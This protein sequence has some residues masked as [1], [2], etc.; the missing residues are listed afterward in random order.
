MTART[1]QIV[2]QEIAALVAEF[3][4]LT[5]APKPFVPGE[6]VVPVSGKVIDGADLQNLVEARRDGWLTTGRFND[7]VEV[8]RAE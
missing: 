1:P 4:E 5:Y 3:A 6:T 2:R 7:A 8:K